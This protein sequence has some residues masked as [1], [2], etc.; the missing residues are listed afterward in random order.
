MQ[1]VCIHTAVNVDTK[2]H[3]QGIRGKDK[4][5]WPQEGMEICS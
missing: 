3:E 2:G 1:Y 5:R 4:D